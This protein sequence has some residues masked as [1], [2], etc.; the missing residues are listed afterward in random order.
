MHELKRT[1][2]MKTITNRCL[3]ANKQSKVLTE[4][5]RILGKIRSLFWFYEINQNSAEKELQHTKL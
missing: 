5:A 1:F 4:V 3:L 2:A